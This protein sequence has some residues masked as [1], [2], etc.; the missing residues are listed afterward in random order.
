MYEILKQRYQ[1]NFVRKDQLLKYVA[2]GKITK[3]EYQQIIDDVS[4]QEMQNILIHYKKLGKNEDRYADSFNNI[5]AQYTDQQLKIIIK[6]LPI[7]VRAV[8]EAECPKY[9]ELVTY[10]G[11][12]DQER[13]AKQNQKPNQPTKQN[14]VSI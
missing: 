5:A 6:C 13:K 9:Q 1:R 2:L 3:E 4:E 10:A 11:E 14:Q 8:L 12:S 7:N